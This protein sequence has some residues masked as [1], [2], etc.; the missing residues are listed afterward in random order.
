MVE[1]IGAPV[2]V[3]PPAFEL[4]EPAFD[5]PLAGSF[6]HLTADRRRALLRVPR[7]GVFGVS[8]GAHVTFDPA[9]AVGEEAV[10]AWLHGPVAALLLA[11]RG[12]FALHASVVDVDGVGVAVAGPRGA[13]K[14]TT[15]LRLAQLGRPLVTDDVTPLLLGDR[16]TVEPF[17]RP[18]HVFAE[19]AHSL[20]LDIANARPVLP[21][22][23]K[24]AVPTTVREPVELG[25]VAVLQVSD[26]DAGV[27]VGRAQGGRAHWLLVS[28]AYRADVLRELWEYELFAWASGL[29]AR[30]P[31]HVVTRPAGRWTVDGVAEAVEELGPAT[32]SRS[33]T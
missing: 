32:S 5:R 30:V 22:H 25:A 1:L 7:V 10:S 21:E 31:V 6:A 13:G 19:T 17:R 33:A 18:V 12:R 16:A 29:A 15:A 4:C 20:G 3:A 14:S 26:E 11:Q 2:E 24:L 28:N 8:D 23:P 27:R 9:P